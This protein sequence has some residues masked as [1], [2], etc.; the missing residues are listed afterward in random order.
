LLGEFE[1]RRRISFI[2]DSSLASRAASE[3]GLA[4][5]ELRGRAALLPLA[6]FRAAGLRRRDLTD[7]ALERRLIAFPKAQDKAL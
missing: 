6:R 7:P 5:A 2:A 3:C 4:T 1:I